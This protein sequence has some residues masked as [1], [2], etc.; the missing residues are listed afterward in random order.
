MKT[1]NDRN[2]WERLSRR[3]RVTW[4]KVQLKAGRFPNA[5]K[6]AQKFEVSEKTAQRTFEYL[7][8]VLNEPIEYSATDRGWQYT[9]ATYPMSV[10][11][12][13]EGELVAMLLASQLARQ[14]RGTAI[15]HHVERVIG[16]VMGAM[17][18]EISVDVNALEE[19]HS[20][21]AATCNELEF[22]LLRQLERS[23]VGRCGLEMTYYTASRGE[24][25]RRRVDPLHLHNYLG[26]WYLIAFDHKRQQV[27][28][29]HAGRISELKVTDERFER[30]ADFNKDEYLTS[31]FGMIRGR[32]PME[33]EI[34]FDEYQARW[35]RERG[36]IHPT[37]KM[38]EQPDGSLKVRMTV[39]A[40]DGVKR[41]VLQYGS[42]VKVAAPIELRDAIREEIRL[43]RR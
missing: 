36:P 9:E 16:R 32:Q 38:E 13:P 40:L 30:P 4:I 19:A 39:G 23:I 6:V 27:R 25:T 43:I 22:D 1:G 21:E 33:V 7:C 11:D 35:I 29:F 24:F 37:A 2:S 3:E 41:F 17:T 14:Y 5:R 42:H 20:F 8:D 26:D 34:L 12:V 18:D 10:V 28:D 15:G 31:G